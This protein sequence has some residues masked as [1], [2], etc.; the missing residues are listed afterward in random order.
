M[1]NA[2]CIFLLSIYTILHDA[3]IKAS[4]V[5]RNLYSASLWRCFLKI[6]RQSDKIIHFKF[7][8][9]SK[10]KKYHSQVLAPLLQRSCHI[11]EIVFH[12]LY[13][14]ANR[15]PLQQ[16]IKVVLLNETYPLGYISK[17]IGDSKDRTEAE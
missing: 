12:E 9:G 10:I 4:A 16:A 3:D 5:W 6:L 1:R 11:I 17:L 8:N 7:N 13:R 15:L 2:V 14:S